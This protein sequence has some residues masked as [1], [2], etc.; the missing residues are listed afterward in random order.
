[1]VG[2]MGG[3]D[4]NPK[5]ALEIRS[6]VSKVQLSASLLSCILFACVYWLFASTTENSRV[7]DS[8]VVRVVSACAAASYLTTSANTILAALYAPTARGYDEDGEKKRGGGDGESQH[9]VK[10]CI[11]VINGI[12]A[13]AHV[14]IALGASPII[15]GLGGCRLHAARMAEWVS[16]MPTLMVLLHSY[17]VERNG[18]LFRPHRKVEEPGQQRLSWPERLAAKV[19]RSL[20]GARPISVVLP[21]LSSSST[22][23]LLLQKTT[24]LVSVWDVLGRSALI[25]VSSQTVSCFI[26]TVAGL[27]EMPLWAVVLLLTV[28]V[29]LYAN[30]FWILYLLVA[31]T[32]IDDD[33]NSVTGG[34]K[35]QQQPAAESRGGG[36]QSSSS[37]SSSSSRRPTSKGPGAQGKLP[38]VEEAPD[39]APLESFRGFTFK[40]WVAAYE[41]R[42]R[43]THVLN[44]AITC[45]TLWTAIVVVFFLSIAGIFSN[46][47]QALLFTALDLASKGLYV[48]ALGEATSL[49]LARES[50]IRHLLDLE[51]AATAQRRHFLRFVMHEV[52]V[53]LNAV[54]LG[55][56]TI[57]EAVTGMMATTKDRSS[58]KETRNHQ[59]R[60]EATTKKVADDGQGPGSFDQGD[61]VD[62]RED[63]RLDDENDDD[64]D[65]PPGRSIPCS[66][67]ENQVLS[68]NMTP[69][70]DL[71]E[72][73]EVVDRSI[74]V[75]SE[76]LNDVLS[77]AA[78][79][80]GRF[81]L[82]CSPFRVKDMLAMVLATHGPTAKEKGIELLS[83]IDAA[84]SDLRLYGDHRRIGACV[85]NYVSNALKFSKDTKD[86]RVSVIAQCHRNVDAWACRNFPPNDAALNSSS[87]S[88]AAN[89]NNSSNSNSSNSNSSNN[90]APQQ[91]NND[92]E[93]SAYPEV[94]FLTIDVSD[95]GHGI[96]KEDQARLFH[97]FS[98]I[99][100]GDLQEGRGSGL[101]LAISR[102][103]VERH[104]GQIGV[105][106]ELALGSTFTLRIPLAVVASPAADDVDH[107][108]GQ[109]A[110][111]DFLARRATAAD[112][113]RATRVAQGHKLR[114]LVVDDVP[115]NRKLLAMQIR[116]LGFDVAGEAENGLVAIGKCG[117]PQRQPPS[118]PS[119]EQRGA[120]S[121]P[122]TLAPS[123]GI[124]RV[125]TDDDDDDPHEQKRQ[126][127]DEAQKTFDIIF[128]DSV[129]PVMSG[130]QA[131]AAL[132]AA[133]C[134]ALIIG[135]TGNALDEDVRAFIDAGA[136]AVLTKPVSKTQ[137][138]AML[139][140]FGLLAP[141][142]CDN[143]VNGG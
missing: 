54:K 65:G 12:S 55:L 13:L 136:N 50:A 8:M 68:S 126:E 123:L 125:V 47:V 15:R 133:G 101:G 6:A 114:V 3:S 109:N 95:N 44:L 39:S 63:Q 117:I 66:G 70:T 23:S 141:G 46:N 140:D 99:R 42:T 74:D 5:R 91:Q 19:R 107:E 32:P 45:A 79:E 76:T 71:R 93:A 33:A 139:R 38:S 82:H 90:E 100:P 97:A 28:S 41:Q 137:I 127:K 120:S 135:V 9:Y 80:E 104:G 86:A 111:A 119:E 92:D 36:A 29:V 37:S 17:D 58:P 83:S 106:S 115:S 112:R 26:G 96:A 48:S 118:S 129:M 113:A 57:T 21:V 18:N 27:Y 131:V 4:P 81:D 20:A 122:T 110:A 14:L 25:S 60:T 132:R 40:H 67:R 138:K 62:D 30:I 34:S 2:S 22:S 103:V 1:M 78:I 142:H 134:D 77:F 51:Q 43:R 89:N 31:E 16:V 35:N 94:V 7:R 24:D 52:R 59:R 102:E 128:M 108:S 11:L 88:S 130:N 69:S 124:T 10:I 53:P 105:Q 85:S 143:A 61:G 49:A 87:S 116:R 121:S 84:L 75:M 73:M 72:I 56:A 98:Q 64:D